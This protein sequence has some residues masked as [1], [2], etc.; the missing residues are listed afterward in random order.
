MDIRLLLAAAA[1]ALAYHTYLRINR[2]EDAVVALAGEE[3]VVH[4]G[5]PVLDMPNASGDTE[6]A[7][8]KFGFHN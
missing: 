1:G 3:P 6:D 2:L 4:L 5:R 8:F 7:K